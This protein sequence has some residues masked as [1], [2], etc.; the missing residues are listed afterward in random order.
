[1]LYKREEAKDVRGSST[2]EFVTTEDEE[3]LPPP[4]PKQETAEVVWPLNGYDAERNRVGPF[5]LSPPFRRVWMFRARQLIEFPPAIAYGR[6]YFTN[7]SG[8]MFASTRRPASAPGSCRSAAA[9]QRLRRS[10]TAPSTS[11]S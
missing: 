7:N 2:E 9:S 1:M 5:D 6:L 10:R 11:R 8:V 3:P 4:P